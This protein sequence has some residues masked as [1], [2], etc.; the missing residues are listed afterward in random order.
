MKKITLYLI[1]S[2]GLATDY[3]VSTTGHLQNNGSFNQPFLK[4][5][6]CADIMQPGD[7]CYI[8]QGQYH[9]NI[10][11]NNKNGNSL[12]PLIFTNYKLDIIR[13]LY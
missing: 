9:E 5:Q 13:L 1:F 3:Y 11:V 7:T 2:F 10:I 8:R 6:Q 12:N 4:I